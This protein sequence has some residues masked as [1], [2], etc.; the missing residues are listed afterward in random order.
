M[1]ADM[2]VLGL[3]DMIHEWKLKH[4]GCLHSDNKH[5]QNSGNAAH[6]LQKRS[7][8]LVHSFQNSSY[9]LLQQLKPKKFPHL[10][11]TVYA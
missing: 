10:R 9:I 1:F 7:R 4:M 5:F 2:F 8:L 11:E 6:T 3:A